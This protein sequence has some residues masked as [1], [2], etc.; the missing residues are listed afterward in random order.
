MFK[1]MLT[2]NTYTVY[3]IETHSLYQS[4]H[5]LYPFE[6]ESKVKTARRFN[7]FRRLSE[8]LRKEKSLKGLALPLV[9]SSLKKAD[10][11]EIEERKRQFEFTLK[12][13]V[14]RDEVLDLVAVRFFLL[15]EEPFDDEFV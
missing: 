3:E 14:R 12:E 13:L 5:E 15:T 2:G 7:E 11:K 4:T 9:E 10:V 6:F 8:Y 1:A